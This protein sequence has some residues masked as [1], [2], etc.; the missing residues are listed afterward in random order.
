MHPLH[1][2]RHLRSGAA[3]LP[4]VRSAARGRQGGGRRIL[5]FVALLA[6]A[7]AGAARSVDLRAAEAPR[8][9]RVQGSTTFNHRLVEPHRGEIE[10]RSGVKI[11]VIPSKSIWGLIA[12]I[13]K[14]ADLAMISASLESEMDA[15]L[16]TLDVEALND[17]KAYEIARLRVAFAVHPRNPVR[18]LTR[19][20]VRAIL[21]GDVRNWKELGG[22][23]LPIRVIATQDG[24]GTVAAVRT[25][26]LDNLPIQAPEAIRIESA[27]QVVKVA[28]QEPGSFT[29]AQL[30]LATGVG[31]VEVT[32]PEPIE[33]VLSL[34]VKGEPTAEMAALIDATRGVALKLEF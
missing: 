16:K 28:A 30:S 7:T 8:V 27:T 32:L 22:P 13:E 21:L 29:I 15:L 33:Q 12:L 10:T 25:Q 1:L 18:Y 2:L 9:L 23:D 17:L 11:N 34:V 20:Q 4:C 24:G 6:L 5:A 19:R 14:R 26:L 3:C 31:L